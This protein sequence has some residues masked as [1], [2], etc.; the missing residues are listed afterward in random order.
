VKVAYTRQD[1]SFDEAFAASRSAG[2]DQF[3][4][5]GQRYHTRRADDPKPHKLPVITRMEEQT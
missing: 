2:A 3:V 4:W 1:A 5:R